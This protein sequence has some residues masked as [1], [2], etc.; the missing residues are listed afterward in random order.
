MIPHEQIVNL[1]SMR[2]NFALLGGRVVSVFEGDPPL[3]SIAVWRLDVT[4]NL[5]DDG[6]ASDGVLEIGALGILLLIDF[7]ATRGAP[8]RSGKVIL[9]RLLK[10]FP[11]SANASA[12]I[13]AT[14]SAALEHPGFGGEH[15]FF[16]TCALCQ[17]QDWS[18]E[19]HDVEVIGLPKIVTH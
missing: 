1:S 13:T 4:R 11:G 5:N 8:V 14:V 19:T 3:D 2:I 6:V 15:S 18:T 16:T 17:M 7:V 9:D 12:M 10:F